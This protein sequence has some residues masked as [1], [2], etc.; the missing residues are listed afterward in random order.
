MPEMVPAYQLSAKPDSKPQDAADPGKEQF[1]SLINNERAKIKGNS[2]QKE[3]VRSED[4]VKQEEG[5]NIDRAACN[6]CATDI[7]GTRHEAMGN[8][9]VEGPEDIKEVDEDGQYT[10]DETA[11]GNGLKIGELLFTLLNEYMTD[12]G[13]SSSPVSNSGETPEEAGV[14]A[15]GAASENGLKAG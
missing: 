15:D 7:N 13:A 2:L 4:E 1:A 14:P 5:S 8:E 9:D 6:H 12:I 3:E 10:E 11:P